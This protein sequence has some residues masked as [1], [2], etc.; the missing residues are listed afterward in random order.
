MTL[1]EV[2]LASFLLGVGLLVLVTGAGRCAAVMR[3]AALFQEARWVMDQGEV[4]HPLI[5]TNDVSVLEVS[6]TEYPN[7]FTYQR[8]VED[9]EDEDGLFV[10]RSRVSWS[11]QGRGSFEEVVR[12]VYVEPRRE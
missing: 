3:K 6:E 7:G 9:D 2:M 8:V 1:I 5:R 4:D 11:R 12:Y 10:V